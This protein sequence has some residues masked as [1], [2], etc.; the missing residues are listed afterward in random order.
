MIN[1]NPVREESKKARAGSRQRTQIYSPSHILSN[2]VQPSGKQASETSALI[3]TGEV[4][5]NIMIFLYKRYIRI[6][7]LNIN[8]Y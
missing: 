6:N 3:S 2:I 1:I 5:P 7:N 8:T 4:A